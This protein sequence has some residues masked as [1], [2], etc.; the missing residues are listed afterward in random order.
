MFCTLYHTVC[1]SRLFQRLFVASYELVEP[2]PI[3]SWTTAQRA[4]QWQRQALPQHMV[5]CQCSQCMG[6]G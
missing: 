2:S 1:S 6:A 3:T 4:C 5:L